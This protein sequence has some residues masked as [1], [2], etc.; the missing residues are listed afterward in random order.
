ML[1][2]T[3]VAEPKLTDAAAV[4]R[5]QI[6]AQ[7]VVV[8]LVE[9]GTGAEADTACPCRRG[10]EQFVAA[11]RVQRDPVVVHVHVQIVAVG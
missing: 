8:E 3:E 9:V 4:A 5:A 6:P 11:R 2:V 1:D 10:R 7:P